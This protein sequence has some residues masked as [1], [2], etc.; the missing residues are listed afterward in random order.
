[1]CDRSHQHTSHQHWH[2]RGLVD[3][4][5]FLGPRAVAVQTYMQVPFAAESKRGNSRSELERQS[6][7]G[8][9]YLYVL[10]R[11][12]L[13]SRSAVRSKLWFHASDEPEQIPYCSYDGV[14]VKIDMVTVMKV[15]TYN[16]DLYYNYPH[17]F[18]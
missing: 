18:Q 4:L 2:C 9:A 6:N 5:I 3:L 7:R 11:Q 8:Q 14:H 13:R 1:M 17:T 10:Q 12:I 15:R 16:A